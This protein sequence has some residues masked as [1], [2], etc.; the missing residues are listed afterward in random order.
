M[1]SARRAPMKT[2]SQPPHPEANNIGMPGQNGSLSSLPRVLVSRDLELDVDVIVRARPAVRRELLTGDSCNLL[3]PDLPRSGIEEHI[4]VVSTVERGD[5]AVVVRI[6][7]VSLDH[8]DADGH[9]GLSKIV[10][11]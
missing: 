2:P 1:R 4:L 9:D 7:G 6:R 3:T 5:G 11:G 8:A 10:S